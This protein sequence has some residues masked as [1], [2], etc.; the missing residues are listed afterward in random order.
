MRVVTIIQARMGSTRL[1]GKVLEAIAGRSVLACTVERARRSALAEETVVAST[2][3]PADVAIEAECRRLGVPCFRG[4][5]P[6]VLDRYLQAA[7][8][9]QAGAI[10]RVTAD[11]PLIDPRVMD[12]VIGAFLAEGPDYASNTLE[13]SYPRGLDTE[14]VSLEALERAG[15]EAVDPGQ[16]EHV[17]LYVWK[18]PA[19]FR[20]LS[21]RAEQNLGH[22][23]WCVDVAEDLELVRAIYGR[24]GDDPSWEEVLALMEREPELVKINAHVAQKPLEG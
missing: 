15:R 24:L 17:T 20:L 1:P 14:V 2:D 4:S 9:F 11:C 22:H 18:N 12:R 6:D 5:E 3:R 21:V 23:R 19:L 13:R 16:R 8:L 7:R 10:V